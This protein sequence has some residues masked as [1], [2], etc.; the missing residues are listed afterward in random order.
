MHADRSK[1]MNS[2]AS[3]C[4]VSGAVSHSFGKTVAALVTRDNV[5]IAEEDLAAL[6][7]FGESHRAC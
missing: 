5:E 4:G 2:S 1:S 7:R 6:L 3:S